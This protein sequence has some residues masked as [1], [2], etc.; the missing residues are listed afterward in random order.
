VIL[1]KIEVKTVEDVPGRRLDD[2]GWPKVQ[3]AN[4]DFDSY[5][6]A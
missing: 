6:L 2:M 1:V 5:D 4:Q 3:T